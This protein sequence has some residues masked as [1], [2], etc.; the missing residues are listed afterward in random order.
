MNWR[1]I[2]KDIKKKNILAEIGISKLMVIFN[3]SAIYSWLTL[4]TSIGT[5]P[6]NVSQCIQI[7]KMQ[8][9]R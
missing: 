8:K 9:P 3:C 1:T 2:K 6:R 7:L 5:A 4:L